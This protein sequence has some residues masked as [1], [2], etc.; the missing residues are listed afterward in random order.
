ML[1]LRLDCLVL[2]LKPILQKPVNLPQTNVSS[3]S[4]IRE[5]GKLWLGLFAINWRMYKTT[6]CFSVQGI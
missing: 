3:C 6:S 1:I 2:L 5:L 4:L